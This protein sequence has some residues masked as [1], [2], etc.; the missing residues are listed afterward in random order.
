MGHDF[1]VHKI[2]VLYENVHKIEI[3]LVFVFFKLTQHNI[4]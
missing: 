4:L 2:L 3:Y 1:W